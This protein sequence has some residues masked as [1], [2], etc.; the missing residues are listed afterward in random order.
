[1]LGLSLRHVRRLLAAYRK[2][3]AAA[4]AHGN[5]GGKPRHT[6]DA[7]RRRRVLE[8]AQSTY[9]G[10]NTQHLTEIMAEREGI[11]L[12]RSTVRRILLE[13][14]IRS[15][16]KRRPPKHR[17]RRERYPQKGMLLQIDGPP[18]AGHD[19]LQGRG[20]YLSLIGAIDDATNEVPYA[21]FRQQEDAQGYF[22][23]LRQIVASHGIPLA[24]YHDRHGIFE[25]SPKESESLEEQLAGERKPTQ[26]G[27]LLQELGITS[28]PSYSPQARGRI[29]RLWGTSQDRLVAEL[30]LA[31]AR[32][33][34]EANQV[35]WHFI[36]GYNSKFMVPA[37]EPGSAYSQPRQ[38][39]IPHEVFCF[40][41]QR[42]VGADNVVSFGNHRLQI[43]PGN[44]RLSYARAK[45][46]VHERL[47]GSLALYYQGHC[48]ASKP[49]PSDAP[50]LRA[51]QL[52]RVTPSITKPNNPLPQVTSHQ[53]TQKPKRDPYLKPAPNHPWRR[54]FKIYIDRG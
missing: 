51:R 30:R 14:G 8:L 28:I 53:K 7:N 6:V 18:E 21:L 50:T 39:F 54:P 27:R 44:G 36:P 24:L 35:L 10:F 1:M 11:V 32:T 52:P 2:E 9:T 20:P 12:S 47:D 22:L 43:E 26:F 46:E 38:G 4:I 16:R 25:R 19:W 34:Q 37:A 49:A 42:T 33:L 31:G 13:A 45:V 41:Y 17:S 29:E 23:L 15:P 48:L 5:R 40:K 3:G